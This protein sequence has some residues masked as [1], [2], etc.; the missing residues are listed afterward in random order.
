MISLVMPR[1]FVAIDLPEP[2]KD[3]LAG[4]C[5]G[6]HGARWV[7]DG[8]FHITL[9]FLGQV[10]GPAARQVQEG[11]AGVRC[12]PFTLRLS[13]IGHF[14][15]RGQPKVLW[16]GV[17][18]DDELRLLQGR[19]NSRLKRLGLPGESR[20]YAPHV[21]LARLSRPAMAPLLQYMGDH[22][23]FESEPFA[24]TDFQLFSSVLGRSGAVHRVE[25][26]YPLMGR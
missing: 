9:S 1:L 17:Q 16:T 10:E 20:R 23:S 22:A 6:V 18:P 11:L 24:V 5:Q 15:P 21:T 13:G 3:R 8:Q 26:S 25:A 14:P 12:D 2:L 4:L 7:T 19:V